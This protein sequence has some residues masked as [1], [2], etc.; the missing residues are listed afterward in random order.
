VHWVFRGYQVLFQSSAT[1]DER[2]K[3]Q[4]DGKTGQPCQDVIILFNIVCTDQVPCAPVDQS[5]PGRF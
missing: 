1:D 5:R 4:G 2:E 3:M